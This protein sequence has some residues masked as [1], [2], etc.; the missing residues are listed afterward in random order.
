MIYLKRFYEKEESSLYNYLK[1]VSSLSNK[2]KLFL[3]EEKDYFN[4][5]LKD[6]NNLLSDITEYEF[7]KIKKFEYEDYMDS[8]IGSSRMYSNFKRHR[9]NKILSSDKDKKLFHFTKFGIP[10]LILITKDKDDY[11]HLDLVIEENDFIHFEFPFIFDQ[12]SELI[13]FLRIFH[14]SEP[15]STIYGNK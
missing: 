1:L 13:K 8:S 14:S 5:L 15:K 2:F 10:S 4:C 12:L 7:Q 9:D 11:F 6:D 3:D